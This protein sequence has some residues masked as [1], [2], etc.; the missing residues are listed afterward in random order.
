MQWFLE[1][2]DICLIMGRCFMSKQNLLLWKLERFIKVRSFAQEA[3]TVLCNLDNKL[4]A[5]NIKL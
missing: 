3:E 4:H 2:A 1:V 5:L